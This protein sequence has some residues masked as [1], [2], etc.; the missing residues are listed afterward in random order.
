MT[1]ELVPLGDT[2][3]LVNFQQKIDPE[4]LRLVM[5]LFGKVEQSRIPGIKFIV[6]AYCSLTVGYDPKIISYPV[7][8]HR[9]RKLL[10]QPQSATAVSGK[11]FIIPVCYQEPYALDMSEVSK[12]SGLSKDEIIDIHTAGSY[13]VYMLGFLPGFPYLGIL[14]EKLQFPRRPRPRVKIQERSVGIAGK[15]TGI[16]PSDSPGG[17]NILGSTPISVFNPRSDDPFLFSTG[18]QVQFKP[19]SNEEYHGIR[20]EIENNTFN[21]ETLYG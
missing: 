14:P 10:K 21:W 9:L 16:Y 7:L 3:L 6:P 18:D 15:Q 1:A 8:K 13:R 5:D 20:R 11:S 12:A 19:V 4:V 2:A 17:W